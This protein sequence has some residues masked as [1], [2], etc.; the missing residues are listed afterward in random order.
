MSFE[1]IVENAK[2]CIKVSRNIGTDSNPRFIAFTAPSSICSEKVRCVLAIKGV[3]YIHYDV[4]LFS[5]ENYQPA[6]VQMRAL[7]WTGRSLIGEKEWTGSTSTTS[8]G[9]DPLVVP[10]FG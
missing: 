4:D 5:L 1:E 2:K 3:P 8:A 7:G 6:Y 9:F 10:T